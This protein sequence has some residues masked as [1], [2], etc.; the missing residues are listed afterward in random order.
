MSG[1]V[2]IV[3]FALGSIGAAGLL[4]W[5]LTGLPGFGRV[6]ATPMCR[7]ALQSG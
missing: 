5:G 4:V 7:S 1:C 6:C 2:R 3:L